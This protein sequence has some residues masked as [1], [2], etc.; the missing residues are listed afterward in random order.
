MSNN[1]NRF[2]NF[3][4]TIDLARNSIILSL[5]LIF[6]QQDAREVTHKKTFWSII[7]SKILPQPITT[8]FD[9]YI[10]VLIYLPT[11]GITI[12]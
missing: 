6:I 5:R 8:I 3:I 12:T 7:V 1:L 10:L 4:V 2:Q 9:R 11:M